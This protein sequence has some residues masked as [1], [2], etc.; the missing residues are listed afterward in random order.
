MRGCWEVR[1][2]RGWEA[3]EERSLARDLDILVGI[4]IPIHCSVLTS[5]D[6]VNVTWVSLACGSLKDIERTTA[7]NIRDDNHCWESRLR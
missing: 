5:L 3:D 7:F 2:L 1:R 6:K 4:L